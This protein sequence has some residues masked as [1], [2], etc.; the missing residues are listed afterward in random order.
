MLVDLVL[1]A[2]REDLLLAPVRHITKGIAAN[3]VGE[4]LFVGPFA[5]DQVRG[6]VADILPQRRAAMPLGRSQ[7]VDHSCELVFKVLLLPLDNVVVHPNSDHPAYS[8]DLCGET[9]TA[10]PVG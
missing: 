2:T 3:E 9:P 4:R 8:P 1:R 6:V 7:A 5:G 10:N